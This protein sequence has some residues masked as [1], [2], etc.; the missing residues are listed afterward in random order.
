MTDENDND[1]TTEEPT[2]AFSWRAADGMHRRDDVHQTATHRD[3]PRIKI[4]LTDADT[5][6]DLDLDVE[7][8]WWL[9]EAILE[10]LPAEEE[11]R[12]RETYGYDED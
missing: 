4:Y 7:R 12:L 11:Q 3:V 5:N 1:A 2:H 9:A 8:A 6:V 10:A